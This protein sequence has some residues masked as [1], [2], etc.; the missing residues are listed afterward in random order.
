MKKFSEDFT[1]R[2][3]LRDLV[4]ALNIEANVRMLHKASTVNIIGEVR[5]QI[6]KLRLK[7]GYDLIS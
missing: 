5:K 4:H 1:P 6:K 7:L 3:D 2:P